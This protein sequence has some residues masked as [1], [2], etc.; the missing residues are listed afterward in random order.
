[1]NNPFPFESMLT[2]GFLS[3]LLLLG[4]AIRAKM[5]LFQRMLIPSCLIGGAI[6]LLVLH[7]STL[8]S[9]LD[10]LEVYAYH[11]FNISFISIGLTKDEP[12]ATS[13]FGGK[14]LLRGASW[15]ALVQGVN[16]PIQAVISALIVIGLSFFG[17]E[18]FP[19]FGFLAPL[20]FN[21]GP[22]QA[23]SM[24]KAWEALGFEHG[25]AIGLTFATIGY[26]FGFLIGV[27]LVNYG[28]KKG[29]AAFGAKTLSKELLVGIHH[30]DG[31]KEI[32]G[33]LTIHSGNADTLAFHLAMVG[34]VY[35]VTYLLVAGLSAI[36]A[37]D[38]QAILWGF[39]FFFGL[40]VALLVKSVIS[41]IGVDHLTDPG[42]QKR[43]SGMSIDYLTIAT[44]CAI[45]LAVVWRFAVPIFLTALLVGLATTVLVIFLSTGLDNYRLERAA[46]IYGT[47]TGTVSC[48]LLL[49]RIADPEFRTPAAYEVG[50]MNIFSLPI[51]G[52]CMALLNAPIWWGWSLWLTLLVFLAMAIISASL[53]KILK[54]WKPPTKVKDI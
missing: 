14:D 48:G 28:I 4:V 54:L 20:G 37:P 38:V 24:G 25:G 35:T 5:G 44:V 8:E 29:M 19:T 17:T 15:M 23:L 1:M 31:A 10:S 41:F 39:F 33:S 36:F 47:V 51:I 18:L 52:V 27:P 3:C 49:V 22:G 9:Q 40:V 26:A 45:Q 30:R 12:A 21:E 2:F 7:I 13:G 42:I 53:L 11:F 50:I 46:A 43:I 32:A 16:F 34:F 6:G